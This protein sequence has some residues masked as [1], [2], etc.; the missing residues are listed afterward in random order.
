MIHPKT[1]LRL[2]SKEIGYG[3]VA[4]EFIP[5]GTITWVLD[6]LDREFT[7][8]Q[9]KKM[10]PLYQ[11]ILD[12]YCYRNN[13]GNLVLCWDYGRYVNHSFKSNCLST[14]YD[15]EIAIRDIQPG[16]EL[17]DDYGYLNVSEPFKGVDEGT[18]RKTVYPDDLLK[19]Y[20]SWDK[21]LNQ[22]FP[23]ITKVEQPLKELISP[24]LWDE[25]IKIADGKKE[26]ESILK[27]HFSG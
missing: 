4:K 7:P 27:N 5:A 10:N 25:I 18:K 11:N 23:K 19:N 3:V 12:T 13:K 9:F 6:E 16:E 17:T 15:F 1:E 22:N 21:K 20:K 26:M 2:I 24:K 14:A 8:A